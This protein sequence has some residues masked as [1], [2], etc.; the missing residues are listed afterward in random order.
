MFIREK[1]RYLMIIEMIFLFDNISKM[2]Y[3]I[4]LFD[5]FLVNIILVECCLIL[6][7]K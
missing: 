7:Y 3:R 6:I 5:K 4:F 1:F 2:S